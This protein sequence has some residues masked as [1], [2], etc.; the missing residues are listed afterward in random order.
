MQT[1]AFWGGGK[2]AEVKKGGVY[3]TEQGRVLLAR[4][5]V[6]GLSAGAGKKTGESACKKERS[7]FRK[8]L[9]GKGKHEKKGNEGVLC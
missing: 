5:K 3:L 7:T 4:W 1:A 8:D 2:S 6:K 9:Q